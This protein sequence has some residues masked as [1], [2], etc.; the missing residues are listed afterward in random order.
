LTKVLDGREFRVEEMPGM[1]VP[2]TMASRR[3]TELVFATI[4]EIM[5]EVERLRGGYI[6]TGKWT[7]GQICDHL[8][9]LFRASVEGFPKQ[10]PTVFRRLVGPLA[11]RWLD[12]RGSMPAGLPAP[13]M[14]AP[15]M[16]DDDAGIEAL[17]AA[18]DRFRGAPGPMA[19]SP[20]AGRLTKAQW[21]RI[22][23]IH[24]A[25]HLGF[26]VPTGGATGG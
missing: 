18:I 13:R 24:S 11:Y 25:H 7:L 23:C 20:I 19:E 22:H 8:A 14:V 4:D 21:E 6:A 1:N 26:A 12:R 5:P 3:R 10:S 2:T 9:I 15:R 16:E 17:R